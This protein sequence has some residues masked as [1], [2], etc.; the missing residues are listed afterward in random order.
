MNPRPCG[1]EG[2]LGW[3]NNRM[4]IQALARAR[5]SRVS[6]S[7]VSENRLGRGLRSRAHTADKGLK[8][9]DSCRRVFAEAIGSEPPIV[10]KIYHY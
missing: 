2:Y 10:D 6:V 3:E 7:A 4:R 9:A 1:F 5:V 8:P